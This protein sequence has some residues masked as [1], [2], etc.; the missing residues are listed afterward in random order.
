MAVF[1]RREARWAWPPSPAA[2][3]GAGLVV[4]RMCPCGAPGGRENTHTY[5]VR[6][7]PAR[8]WALP[9]DPAPPRPA[10]TVPSPAGGVAPGRVSAPERPVH[11]VASDGE[12]SAAAMMNSSMAVILKTHG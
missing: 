9:G 1:D 12:S 11:G 10:S 6:S 8:A 3:G 2:G 7:A 5:R 4:A